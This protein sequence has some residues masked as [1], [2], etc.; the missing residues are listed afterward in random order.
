[1]NKFR[2]IDVSKWNFANIFVSYNR[3]HIFIY[4]STLLSLS[5]LS[6]C[7][8]N[9]SEPEPLV[10]PVT[11]TGFSFLTAYNPSLANNIQ[12]AIDDN[13][14]TTRAPD[15]ISIENLIATFDHDGFEVT[16]NN[17]LQISG[18][19]AN[20]FSNPITYTV[21]TSDGRRQDYLV[22]LTKFTGLPII[23][24]TTDGNASIASKDDY[25]DG[26]VLFECGRL[27]AGMPAATM[28]I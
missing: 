21:K 13:A 1:M 12:F 6:G 9:S 11:I 26:Y 10:P 19:T 14:I 8:S 18:T 25:V 2:L 4:L 23:Y 27:F 3:R 17:I 16:V 15:G 7:G 28:K 5:L 20:D 22:D 24:I